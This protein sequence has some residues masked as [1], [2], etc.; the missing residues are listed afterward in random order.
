NLM[1]TINKDRD[2][3]YFPHI[4][5]EELVYFYNLASYCCMPSLCEGFGLAPLEAMACKTPVIA[6]QIPALA[7]IYQDSCLYFDPQKLDELKK[8]IMDFSLDKAKRKEFIQKG[9]ATSQKYNWQK[10]AHLTINAYKKAY[11]NSHCA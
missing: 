1:R 7:E 2:I 6:S 11:E 9:F 5:H 10:T 4:S 3:L 8:A